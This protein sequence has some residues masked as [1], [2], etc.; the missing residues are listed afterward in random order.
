MIEKE[1]VINLVVALSKEDEWVRK[2]IAIL[3]LSTTLNP[4]AAAETAGFIMGLVDEENITGS[5]KKPH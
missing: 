5:A 1:D 2:Q 3:L 4:A